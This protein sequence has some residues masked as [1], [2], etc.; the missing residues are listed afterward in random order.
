MSA[1]SS[2]K[3]VNVSSN[4]NASNAI[5]RKFEAINFSAKSTPTIIARDLRIDGELVSAGLIE[6]EGAVCGSIKSHSVI[7]RESGFVDGT[8]IAE[9]LSIRG[10]FDGTIKAKKMM[11][12]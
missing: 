3:P 1:V 9:S 10:R 12:R 2:V 4:D 8:I 5:V 7:L 6:I 11:I